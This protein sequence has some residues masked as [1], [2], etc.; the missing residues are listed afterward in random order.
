MS[1]CPLGY[2]VNFYISYL[3]ENIVKVVLQ[4]S[5]GSR[6]SL[7]IAFICISITQSKENN[8]L[9]MSLRFRPLLWSAQRYSLSPLIKA[10][11]RSVEM[12]VS[13][14]FNSW[15]ESLVQSSIKPCQFSV[16]CLFPVGE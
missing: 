5:T 1:D 16:S 9:T 4:G 3:R 6:T 13:L 12:F 8:V 10:P 15:L 11:D 2:L 7:S 14:N